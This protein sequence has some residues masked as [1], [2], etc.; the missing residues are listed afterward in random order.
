MPWHTQ[1]TAL[2]VLGS[3]RAGGLASTAEASRTGS[4]PT[5]CCCITVS[6]NTKLSRLLRVDHRWSDA[7]GA[8]QVI[9]GRVRADLAGGP[10]HGGRW[11]GHRR[12]PGSGGGRR[13]GCAGRRHSL[14]RLSGAERDRRAARPLHPVRGGRPRQDRSWTPCT[15]RPKSSNRRTAPSSAAARRSLQVASVR[16]RALGCQGPN[17]TK[18]FSRCGMGPCQGRLCG[19]VV[20]QLLGLG[21]W[22]A[23]R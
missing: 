11:G 7:Q 16:W 13:A 23:A 12:G 8:W 14:G 4:R 22:Q 20:T 19:N 21:A 18:F 1:A 6:C 3:S 17:Q 9:A 2:S 15:A 5:P 10:A